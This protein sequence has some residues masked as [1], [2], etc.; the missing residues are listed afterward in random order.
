MPTVL[1]V[2]GYRFFFY[3]SDVGEPCHVHVSKGEGIGKIWLEP[4]IA[5]QYLD[6]F[7]IRQKREVIEI[8]KD[9]EQLLKEKWY[10]FFDK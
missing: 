6:Y 8:V 3:A 1:R 2:N 4:E 9:N 10:G 5:I 7:T